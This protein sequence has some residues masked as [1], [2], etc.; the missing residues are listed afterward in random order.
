MS[1]EEASEMAS[2][3]DLLSGATAEIEISLKTL[4]GKKVKIKKATV[5]EISDIMKVSGDSVLEQFIW[6]AVRCLVS[7]KLNEPEIRKLP[8]NVLL[9]IGTHIAKFSGLDKQSVEKMQNLLQTELSG[10]TS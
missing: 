2:V 7:P 10:A 3:A 6:L 1:K 5:G 8:H 4:P 9:E